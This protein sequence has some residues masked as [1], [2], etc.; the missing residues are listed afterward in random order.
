[1]L[2]AYIN[3]LSPYRKAEEKIAEEIKKIGLN[4]LVRRSRLSGVA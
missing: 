2:A 1:M 3:L 4:I